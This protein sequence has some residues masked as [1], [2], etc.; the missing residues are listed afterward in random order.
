MWLG[1]W[2]RDFDEGLT[3]PGAMLTADDEASEDM[4]ASA[5]EALYTRSNRS[6]V[7][8]IGW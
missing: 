2:S 1:L 8:L 6:A 3:T 7:L 5:K 4:F